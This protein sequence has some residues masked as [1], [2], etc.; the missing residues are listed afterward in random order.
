[1]AGGGEHKHRRHPHHERPDHGYERGD[2]GQEAKE[3]GMR[4]A[5]QRVPAPAATPWNTAA[6]TVPSKVATAT[7]RN[8]SMSSPGLAA[9]KRRHLR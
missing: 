7:L 2:A 1:M 3:E 5:E 9:P 8:S 6:A 4:D